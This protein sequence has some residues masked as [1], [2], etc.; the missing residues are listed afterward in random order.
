MHVAYLMRRVWF[1]I[2]AVAVLSFVGSAEAQRVKRPGKRGRYYKVRIDSSPQ[3]AAIYLDDE[4]A[5]IVGYTPWDGRLQKGSWKV[6]I[7]KDGW[8]TQTKQITV[9][10]TRRVQETFV[11]LVKKE[12]PGMLDVRADAD[13]NAFGAEVWV[14]GQKV[15]KIPVL[16]KVK[17]GR[18]LVEIKKKDF[19]PF[20]Q[21]VEVKEGDRITINPQLRQ[22]AVGSI[23]VEAD[24]GGAEVYVDG[25]KH[26]DT[27]PTL[28]QRLVAGP[29]IVEVRK[30]PAIP[31]KHTIMVK[32]NE[33]VK[34][35][36]QL[37]A[38]M[39]G[40]GGSVRVLSNVEGAEVFLDGTKV[41]KAPIDIKDVKA[42]PHVVEVKAAGHQNREER[43]QVQA[44][45]AMILKL[46][47]IPSGGAAVMVKIVSPVPEAEVFVDG[48]RLGTAPQ[49]KG[50]GPG[51]HFVVVSKKG[52]AKFEQK[53]VVVEGKPQTITAELKAVGGIRFLSRPSG[54][55][56]LIDGVDSGVTPSVREDI[57]VGEHII[58]IQQNG[59]YD[60]QKSLKVEGGKTA[61][62]NATLELID[63]GPSADD[64]I[65]EQ[66][67]QS[68][69][70]AKTLRKEKVNVD[71]GTGYPYI[72]NAA[73][74]IGAGQFGP[75]GLDASLMVR[76]FIART[77]LGMRGR[78]TLVDKRPF[79]LGAFA[80]MG[81]GN[82]FFD[83]SQRNTF[84]FKGGGLASLTG[85][86]RVTITARVYLDM[87]S[88]RYCPSIEEFGQADPAEMCENYAARIGG[89]TMA[90]STEDFDRI[91]ILLGDAAGADGKLFDRDNGV[92]LM[93]SLIVEFAIL[94]RING[95]II[96]EGAP[97]QD[98]RPAFT[99][100]FNSVLFDEDPV[101]YIRAGTTFKF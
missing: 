15:G 13:K 51:E 98:E 76:S 48:A 35:R 61:V 71:V 34:V 22:N 37:K 11:P 45:Q 50:L 68:S 67:S 64:L 8:E 54:A 89:D 83:D 81:G 5:G 59:Y 60:F 66:R 79:S 87:W 53:V 1:V 14:D 77:E 40:P 39:S 101:T 33:T 32:K 7:K 26:P 94:Q 6:I 44:G 17:D 24:V 80:E 10:R 82:T 41:G 90:L 56:I 20:S 75:V 97:F 43:V 18:H 12:Q 23:L 63:T 19:D 21:W 46:D 74:H 29:H 73:F 31:W 58:T 65:A 70:G 25:N 99:D 4:K 52:Y 84:Y 2:A 55:R 28:I 91:N 16:L 27:T 95:W 72:L 42:G 9:R 85:L 86:G 88:D 38:T 57:A 30:A 49:E 96:F 62:L 93:T 36:G 78:V 3:Q 47:L 69:F 100:A 92:R